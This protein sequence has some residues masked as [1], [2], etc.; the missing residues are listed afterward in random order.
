M[1][2]F[3]LPQAPGKFVLAA[4]Q[5]IHYIEAGD[6]KAP[7]L[8][9]IHGLLDSI[10][11]F[12]LVRDELAEHY[13][14]FAL[15]LP[16]HGYSERNPSFSMSLPDQ[17]EVVVDFLKKVKV[18][19]CRVL[20][21][22]MGGGIAIVLASRYP[23]LVKKLILAS[24]ISYPFN[25]PL[26]GKVAL[27]PHLGQYVVRFLFNR[28]LITDYLQKEVYFDISCM[29]DEDTD[30]MWA[31]FKAP[32]SR[33]AMH[34]AILAIEDVDWL[35]AEARKI[36]APTRIIWGEED[37]AVPVA[38]GYRLEADIPG[39]RLDVFKR[40]G[41]MVLCENPAEVKRI[42]ISFFSDEKKKT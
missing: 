19:S 33:M 6:K 10:Q 26:K 20:G 36:K 34:R 22:S 32:E 41:H 37:N 14:V 29:S 16:G 28:Y 13:H 40:C 35:P 9:L 11:A 17:A 30:I 3:V 21:H 7:A 24:T 39:A 8:L 1:S 27:I 23:K 12:R 5:R 4:G 2:E 15:D 18:K 31:N 42:A 25:K 38:L